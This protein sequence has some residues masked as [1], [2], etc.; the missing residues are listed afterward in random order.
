[1]NNNL[2]QGYRA[3]IIIF[4]GLPIRFNSSNSLI[5]CFVYSSHWIAASMHRCSFDNIFW[6][7]SFYLSTSSSFR[8]NESPTIARWIWSVYLEVSTSYLYCTSPLSCFHSDWKK[9]NVAAWSIIKHS[10]YSFSFFRLPTCRND[11]S[12]DFFCCITYHVLVFVCQCCLV[13]KTSSLVH[14]AFGFLLDTLV[15]FSNSKLMKCIQKC[16][17]AHILVI[18]DTHSKR[19]IFYRALMDW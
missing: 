14:T 11:Y 5:N 16:L 10:R 15:L 1:M 17:R 8:I 13:L 19:T 6:E 2:L 18:G 3:F 7:W 9:N 12:L 4:R